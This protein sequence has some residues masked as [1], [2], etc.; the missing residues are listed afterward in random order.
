MRPS[1]AQ[2]AR[3]AEML[4]RRLVAAD[5]LELQAPED[6]VRQRFV[7]VLSKNFDDEEAIDNEATAEAEKIV[8]RGAPGVR[9]EDLDLRKVE[10]LVKQRIAKARGFVL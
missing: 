10:Q 8:R 3:V 7:A 4:A 5:V 2:I 1:A 6:R 9:R